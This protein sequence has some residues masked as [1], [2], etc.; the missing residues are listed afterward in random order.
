[1]DLTINLL[2]SNFILEKKVT[3]T[4]KTYL[5]YILKI[6][7]WYPIYVVQNIYFKNTYLIA[8]EKMILYIYKGLGKKY[9]FKKM[10]IF[11]KYKVRLF[12]Y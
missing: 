8:C 3:K 5:F 1:M 4:I 11:G 10:S 9:I 2:A 6:W 7:Y 12:K